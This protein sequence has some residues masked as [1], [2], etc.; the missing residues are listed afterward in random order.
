MIKRTVGN[1]TFTVDY[2]TTKVICYEGDKVAG[3]AG[4]TDPK[5]FDLDYLI[6]IALKKH[7]DIA[8]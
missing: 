6:S 8:D 7:T 1:K 3:V 2:T 5:F 4:V